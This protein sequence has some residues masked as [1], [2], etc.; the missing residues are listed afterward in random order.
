MVP[1]YLDSIMSKTRM[2]ID[3]Q[4]SLLAAYEIDKSRWPSPATNGLSPEGV[5]ALANDEANDYS[6]I[7]QAILKR[8]DINEETHRRKFRARSREKGESYAELATSLL[9]SANRWLDDCISTTDLLEKVAMEQF[10]SGCGSGNT[11]QRRA[12]KRGSGQT[13]SN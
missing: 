6:S 2:N 7:K 11:S 13:N 9:D 4:H 12:L 5:Y 10:L 1:D 8:Y 3:E